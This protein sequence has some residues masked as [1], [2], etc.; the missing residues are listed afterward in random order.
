MVA[1]P[2][3]VLRVFHDGRQGVEGDRDQERHWA[4]P[5]KIDE[6]SVAFLCHQEPGSCAPSTVLNA[7]RNTKIKWNSTRFPAASKVV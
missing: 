2:E 7:H 6:F 5:L 1:F 4:K 3:A